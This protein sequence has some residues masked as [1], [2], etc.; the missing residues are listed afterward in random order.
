MGQN[1]SVRGHF[2]TVFS[3]IISIVFDQALHY[4]LFL[5]FRSYKAHHRRIQHHTARLK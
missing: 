5:Y 1:Q 3:P 2:S 4:Y